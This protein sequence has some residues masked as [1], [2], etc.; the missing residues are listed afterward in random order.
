[1]KCHLT[2]G[3]DG[4]LTVS[5]VGSEEYDME[6]HLFE[7]SR[8]TDLTT[9]FDA[10]IHTLDAIATGV[11]GHRPLAILGECDKSELPANLYFRD[12]WEWVD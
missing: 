5:Y 1:M 9:H 7:L 8:T 10:S 3:N 4:R 2:P 11:E 12:A 6:K